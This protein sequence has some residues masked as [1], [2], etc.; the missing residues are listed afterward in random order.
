MHLDAAKDPNRPVTERLGE[1]ARAVKE[2]ISEKISGAE[3]E[4]DKQ[5]MKGTFD[6]P[7]TSS[8]TFTGSGTC[9]TGS[10]T[11]DKGTSTCTTSTC[12][13]GCDGTKCKSSTLETGS[14]MGTMKKIPCDSNC[15]PGCDGSKHV[16]GAMG[17]SLP[18]DVNKPSV[19]STYHWEAARD[20]D[21]G[22]LERGVEAAKAFGSKISE[23]LTTTGTTN[24]GTTTTGTGTTT[25]TT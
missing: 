1:G 2:K 24:T 14:G 3:K 21:R 5:K 13:T 7:S 20:P 18:T 16:I 25:K 11:C 15:V 19:A 23:K 8:S 4:V 17:Q 12:P 9:A 10:G 6:T 22:Y